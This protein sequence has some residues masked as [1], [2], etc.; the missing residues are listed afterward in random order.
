VVPFLQSG[1]QIA[2][3]NLDADSGFAAAGNRAD[4]GVTSHNDP[5]SHVFWGWRWKGDLKGGRDSGAAPGYQHDGSNLVVRGRKI[6]DRIAPSGPLAVMVSAMR[7][8]ARF[9]KVIDG[10]DKF[11]GGAG[12][13][14]KGIDIFHLDKDNPPFSSV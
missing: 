7:S 13:G 1:Q 6:G 9:A 14:V 2:D 12:A 3:V 11:F 4:G 5:R 8:G 10:P